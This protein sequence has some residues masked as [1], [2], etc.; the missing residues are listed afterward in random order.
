MAAGS[1]WSC[2]TALRLASLGNAVHVIDFA[3]PLSQTGSYIGV[4]DPVH[5]EN[6]SR[7]AAAGVPVHL[8]SASHP[9]LRYLTA[10]PELARILK[11]TGAE[12][13]L[14]LY[15]GG[16]AVLAMASMFRPF[17]CYVVGSDVLIPKRGLE[18][19]LSRRAL[20]H[21][22]LVLANGEYLAEKT[23]EVAPAANVVPLILGIDVARFGPPKSADGQV[24]VI[25]TRGFLPVYNNESI[26]SAVAEMS[27]D[28]PPFNLTFVSSGPGLAAAVALADEKIPRNTRGRVHFLGGVAREKLMELLRAAD[29]YVSMSRSDGTSTALL[30]AL[31]SGLFPV[32]SD[33]PQHREWL[34]GD[35]V[36]LVPLDDV[37][38][39]AAAIR[40]AVSDPARRERA[41]RVNRSLVKARADAEETGRRL[42][43]MLNGLIP[44]RRLVA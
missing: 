27:D 16:F 41:R 30:E 26:I 8:L 35:N 20:S 22:S 6:V 42:S 31:A 21:A 37:A 32:L 11:S 39:L 5:A 3:I 23:K 43:A 7:L 18:R 4:S 10:A 1:P 15:S 9:R 17:A 2:E 33:I 19:W 28:V 29:V 38:S 44:D 34:E 24:N 40:T 25:C 12:V 14:T 36:I 13:L